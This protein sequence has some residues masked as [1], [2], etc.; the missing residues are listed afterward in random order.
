[1]E[2]VWIKASHRATP[3]IKEVRRAILPCAQKY[4]KYLIAALMPAMDSGITR[5]T[6]LVISRI[7]L[8]TRNRH[9]L[10]PSLEYLCPFHKSALRAHHAKNYNAQRCVKAYRE[11]NRILLSYSE[12]EIA[13]LFLKGHRF[14][15]TYSVHHLFSK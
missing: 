5:Q 6:A 12:P 9:F 1:M 14:D 15:F 10:F 13:I 2:T 7:A 4:R 8:I 11:K 3:S